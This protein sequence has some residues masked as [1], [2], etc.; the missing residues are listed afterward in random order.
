METMED[1]EDRAEQHRRDIAAGQVY[2]HWIYADTAARLEAMIPALTDY[3]YQ[4]PTE[5]WPWPG[6]TV[7]QMPV[8]S[9]SCVESGC[10][11]C[12]LHWLLIVRGSLDIAMAADG[13]D[14]LER[15]CAHAG[16]IYD[17][18]E[19]LIRVGSAEPDSTTV[20]GG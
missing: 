2:E 17:G 7:D 1:A 11:G 6:M 3:G 8:R 13:R 10:T 12:A 20:V 19:F 18:G 14:D 15:E 16:A 4:V 9:A 5:G